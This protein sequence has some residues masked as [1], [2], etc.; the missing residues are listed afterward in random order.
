MATSVKPEELIGE[1]ILRS[2]PIFVHPPWMK[3]EKRKIWT[4]AA[5]LAQPKQM[6]RREGSG[7]IAGDATPPLRRLPP[8]LPPERSSDEEEDLS[9]PDLAKKIPPP[10]PILHKGSRQKKKS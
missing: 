9:G 10:T 1:A 7:L 2:S 5:A 8:L 6:T 3:L 4:L